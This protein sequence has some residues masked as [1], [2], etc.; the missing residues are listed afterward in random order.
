VHPAAERL[1]AA[2]RFG[3]GFSL[4][5]LDVAIIAGSIVCVVIVGLRAA[6]SQDQ[7][8]RG[9]FLASGRLPW[10]LIG[11]AFVSTSVSSEQIVGTVGAAYAGGMGIANWEIWSLPVYAL[12]II[13][14]IPVYLK[15][16]VTTVPDF[17]RR[18]FGPLCADIYSW[19]MLV[20]YVVIF[21]VSVLYGG[22]KAF[23]GLTGWRFSYVLWVMVILVAVYTVKGGLTS[24]MWTDAAQCVMLLGGGIVLFFVALNRV[25]GGILHGWQTMMQASPDRFHLYRPANDPDA[26]FL[27]LLFGSVGLFL[28]YQATNQVMI[29]RVL[30]A[31]S[32]WDGI[33][34]IIF[35]GFIN[36][37][38]PLVTCFLGFIVYHWVH[39]MHMAPPLGDKDD[40]F[41]FALR[42]L[43]PAWGLRGIILA[44]FLAAVMSTISALANSTATIFSLDV[45][46]KI[47]NPRA[48]DQQLVRA[49]RWMSLIALA[50][51]GLLAPCVGRFGGIFLYFQTGVT[52]LATPFISV[53]LVGLFWRRANYAGGIFGVMGGLVI[54]VALALGLPAIGV[55][56][57]RFYVA[58]VAEALTISGIVVVS[59]L[60]APPAREQWEPFLWTPSLLRNFNQGRPRPWYQSVK[61]WLGLFAGIWICLYWR[62][63]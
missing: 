7:S 42:S 55:S 47:I 44:G 48:Q 39:V 21:L 37:L 25:P 63:W 23:A 56:L 45:Y 15:N 32:T 27:G 60:T 9:Y 57:H 11:S 34:G 58:A 13:F 53:V 10:W 28:F 62:F 52:Y 12:L 36:F 50:V 54:Q 20:A 19:V 30:G 61:L 49:G 40:T 16:R 24:V 5:A 33:M 35:A 17:L 43:A 26:P 1:V 29:Q 51:A 38:R 6:W 41:A 3:M 2:T 8:S 14:F 4:S 31:R 59:L 22:T 18:R 46:K